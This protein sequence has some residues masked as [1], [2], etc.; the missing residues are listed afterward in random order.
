VLTAKKSELCVRCCVYFAD[1]RL[2]SILRH[3]NFLRE[4]QD[5]AV[6]GKRQM[7]QFLIGT[8]WTNS[9]S[10]REMLMAAEW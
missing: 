8:A 5:I 10:Y 6:E 3:Q 2:V 1:D 9:V 7:L 4:M